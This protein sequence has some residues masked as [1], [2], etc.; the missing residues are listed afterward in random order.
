MDA[1]ARPVLQ[2]RRAR[3]ARQVLRVLR[4]LRARLVRQARQVP[5]V[6]P[7]PLVRKARQARQVPRV[8]RV[9]RVKQVRQVPR[10]RRVIRVKQ[11]RQVRQVRQARKA[12]RGDKGDPTSLDP[13]DFGNILA[14]VAKVLLIQDGQDP[15]KARNSV[16]P[17]FSSDGLAGVG[18]LVGETTSFSGVALTQSGDPIPAT[19]SWAVN[20]PIIATVDSDGTIEGVRRGTTEVTATVDGRGI[21]LKFKVTVH[22]P[23]KSIVASGGGDI[24]VGS[25]ITLEATAYDAKQDDKKAGIEGN[26]VPD[27]T[28]TWMSSNTAVAS[29]DEDGKVTAEGVGSA[30]ITAHN[31][32][33]TSN[34]VAVNVYSVVAPERRLVVSTA[35]APFVRYL[36]NDGNEDGTADDPILTVAADTTSQV[37]SDIV[38]NVRVQYRGLNNDG[39]LAWLNAANG[40]TVDVSSSNDAVV[41]LDAETL[42]TTDGGIPSGTGHASLTIAASTDGNAQ[43]LKAG[44]VVITFSEDYSASQRVNVEI[45]AKA[46]SGG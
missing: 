5:R 14:S 16:A 19:V 13:G 23:V 41:A 42:T 2:A 27:V 3:P 15:D 29:V 24:E 18:L 28:F 40:L 34:K 37:D 21:E 38:I 31:G 32:D 25:S 36:D 20:D 45:K 6:K 44:K 30:N 12:T 33:V 43:A 7:A 1:K 35:N 46:G 11:V 26:P 4:V 8:R 10:V 17:L 9:I 22:D 39:N